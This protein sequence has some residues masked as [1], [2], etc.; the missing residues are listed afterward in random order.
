MET[1]TTAVQRE[2]D[3]IFGNMEVDRVI[4]IFLVDVRAFMLAFHPVVGD[5][6][7]GA[8]GD[9]QAVMEELAIHR[10]V[11]GKGIADRHIPAP[12]DGLNDLVYLVFGFAAF[13]VGESLRLSYLDQDSRCRTETEVRAVEQ[14]F[15][16]TEGNSA[17]FELDVV[18][19]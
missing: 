14:R 15:V 17:A 12:I 19:A 18:G 3:L 6:I 9:K 10:G 16:A 8:I 13:R 5:R 11:D 7:F 1:L 2:G 4:R